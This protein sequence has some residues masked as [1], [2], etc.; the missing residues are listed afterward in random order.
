MWYKLKRILIYP[1]GVTEKQVYPAWWKPWANTIVYYPLNSDKTVYNLWTL[2]SNYD[3]TNNWVTFSSEWWYFN[4]S[5]WLSTSTNLPDAS[6]YTIA[7]WVKPEK[8]SQ[9]APIM[10]DWDTTASNDFW[11]ECDLDNWIWIRCKSDSGW[12]YKKPSNWNN[13]SRYCVILTMSSSWKWWYV[14]NVSLGTWSGASNVNTNYHH[15]L[16]IG[17]AN[18]WN[19][20]RWPFKWYIWHIVIDT[21]IWNENER[22]NYYNLTKSNYW[23]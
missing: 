18:D 11:I 16:Q 15:Q 21:S 8:Q 22:L 6:Q 14:N 17:R 4:G 7:F 10:Q 19:E 12:T 3:L 5:S 9:F 23:L 2:W 1:D 20:T 13:N